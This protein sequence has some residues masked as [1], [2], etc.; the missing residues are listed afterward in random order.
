MVSSMIANCLMPLPRWPST[1]CV[2]AVAHLVRISG[3]AD[4]VAGVAFDPD[5]STASC[6]SD[7]SQG[8]AKCSSDPAKASSSCG[9]GA[10]RRSDFEKSE[11]QVPARGSSQ[12]APRHAGNSGGGESVEEAGIIFLEGGSSTHFDCGYVLWF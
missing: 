8:T 10:L 7:A 4:M 3:E 5:V 11:S 2:L 6:S 12:E 1:F 9:C